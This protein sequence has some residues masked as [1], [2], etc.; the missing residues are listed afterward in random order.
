MRDHGQYE[1]WENSGLEKRFPTHG[2]PLSIT[3]N[4]G[5][6]FIS[7]VVEQYFTNCGM[8]NRKRTPLWAQANGE[9][10]RQNRSLLKRIKIAQAEKKRDWRKEV[11]TCLS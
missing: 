5:P 10:E 3:S 7:E 9:V 2:L 1:I 6:Q 11:Q 8:E 4:N